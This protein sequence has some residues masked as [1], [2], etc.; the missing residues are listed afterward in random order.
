MSGNEAMSMKR[1]ADEYDQND[2]QWAAA[3]KDLVTV[4]D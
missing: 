3:L 4:V 2:R 1:E